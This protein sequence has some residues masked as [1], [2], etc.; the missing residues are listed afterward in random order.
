MRRDLYGSTEWTWLYA[1]IETIAPA[2]E[3]N[4]LNCRSGSHGARS[5]PS[6]S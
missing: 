1:P 2:A 5:I 3:E 4:F 6:G